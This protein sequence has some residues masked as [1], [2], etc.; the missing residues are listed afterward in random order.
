MK[1]PSISIDPKSRP[2]RENVF[3]EKSKKSLR[4]L[5]KSKLGSC[6]ICRHTGRPMMNKIHVST[7]LFAMKVIENYLRSVEASLLQVNF[8]RI[9]PRLNR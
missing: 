6:P 5:L 9:I 7:P 2:E 4:V 1:A 3:E 8:R